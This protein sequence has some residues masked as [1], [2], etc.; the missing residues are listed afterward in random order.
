LV[1]AAQNAGLRIRRMEFRTFAHPPAAMLAVLS[2]RGLD[3]TFAHSG[4]AW[5]V[6]GLAR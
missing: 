5:Q 2:D 3:A 6:T 4:I 1:V